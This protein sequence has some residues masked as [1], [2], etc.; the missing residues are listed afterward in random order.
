MQMGIEAVKRSL[1][2]TVMH[3]CIVNGKNKFHMAEQT[4][5][6]FMHYPIHF[7][8][9]LDHSVQETTRRQMV[10][11]TDPSDNSVKMA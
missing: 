8:C 1:L 2:I 10:A 11:V 9:C 5:C 7:C 4:I 6:S 3:F